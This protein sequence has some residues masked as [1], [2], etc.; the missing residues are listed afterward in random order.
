MT[1]GVHQE[2][3]GRLFDAYSTA[4]TVRLLYN[5]GRDFEWRGMSENKQ[6][7]TSFPNGHGSC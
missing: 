4:M 2:R 6:Y 1:G 5:P 7:G 3:E